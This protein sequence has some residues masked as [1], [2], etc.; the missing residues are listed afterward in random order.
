MFDCQLP[1]WTSPVRARSP[2][3]QSK[4]LQPNRISG[5]QSNSVR[6]QLDVAADRQMRSGRNLVYF[7]REGYEV[8]AVDPDVQ[9]VERPHPRPDVR[10][11]ASG[12]EFL[13]RGHGPANWRNRKKFD[14]DFLR[15]T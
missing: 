2:A 7:L 12:V 15:Q 4:T 9:A 14:C 1:N 8:Y 3:L 6:S 11:R 13:S 10:A 5:F